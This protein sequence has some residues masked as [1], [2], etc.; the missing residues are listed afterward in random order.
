MNIL[1]I[2]KLSGNMWAGPNN[3]V[4]AQV[5]AQAKVDNVFWY[6]INHNTKTT[7]EE[8]GVFYNLKDYPNKRISELPKPFSKPD[9]VIFEGIYAYPFSPLAY[10]VKKLNIPYILIPRSELTKKAQRHK[11]L[12]KII[13]NIIFF[14]YFIRKAAAIQYLTKEE[15]NDSASKW[16][17]KHLIIPNGIKKRECVRRSLNQTKLKGI[18][19]GR[20]EIY[21]K[22]L[23]MLVE[24]C[25]KTKN[26]M[27]MNNCTIDLY[28]PDREGAKK[29]LTAMISEA[30]VEDLITIN[31]GIFDE[32]K[33]EIQKNADFFIMT[34]RFEGHP[35]GL[36]EA[37][38]YGLP[39][40]V[41]AGTN[42]RKEIEKADAGWA[43]NINVDSIKEALHKLLNDRKNFQDKSLN[44]LK[45]S[46]KYNWDKLAAIS[47]EKYTN[48]L[49]G[50]L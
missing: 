26:E 2:S 19:I 36:I 30:G 29:K 43:A 16:N 20:I 14:K 48:L 45:L 21:Q 7:W 34:S 1:Y 13:G 40:L 33:A 35:M 24:A 6:N 8:S 32:E 3:S 25:E 50:E 23:D 4:P 38:S 10:E 9:L 31:D 37:L 42:M 17:S 49:K 12:K 18:Y 41:T 46:Q 44:A 39:C 27:R 11:P 5:I 15:Y 22:G 28:G 47:H